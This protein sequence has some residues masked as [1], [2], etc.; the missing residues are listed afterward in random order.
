MGSYIFVCKKIKTNSYSVTSILCAATSILNGI[1]IE[2]LRF[3]SSLTLT[4][5]IFYRN[6][7]Y[8]ILLVLEPH[9]FELSWLL[10]RYVIANN[11]GKTCSSMFLTLTKKTNIIHQIKIYKNFWQLLWPPIRQSFLHS[12]NNFFYWLLSNN[13]THE[14]IKF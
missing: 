6:S 11:E 5:K 2:W 13:I 14:R 12:T 1:L 8:L 4:W 7:T 9:P 10:K 3:T